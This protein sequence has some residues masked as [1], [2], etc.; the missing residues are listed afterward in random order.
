MLPERL[1]FLSK[2]DSFYKSLVR[3]IKEDKIDEADFY[4]IIKTKCKA[5]ERERREEANITVNWVD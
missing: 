4:L 3:D 1:K 5:M 2:F